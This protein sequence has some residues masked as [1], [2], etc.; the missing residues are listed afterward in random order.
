[1]AVLIESVQNV[2]HHGHIDNTAKVPCTSRWK[3]HRS[4]TSSLWELDGRGTRL[5]LSQRIGELNNLS[6]AERRKLYVD[7]LCAGQ[8]HPQFGNAGLGLISIAKRAHG[9]IEFLSQDHDCGLQLVTL[10]V[11][12]KR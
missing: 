2:I 5:L 7:V 12:I 8:Q 9:P 1:M 4:A 10:T 11:T 3:T 6:H